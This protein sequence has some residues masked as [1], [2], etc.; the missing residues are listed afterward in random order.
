[1]GTWSHEDTGHRSQGHGDTGPWSHR[2]RG[3]GDTG[4]WGHRATGTPGTGRSP[5]VPSHPRRGAQTRPL[6]FIGSPPRPPPLPIGWLSRRQRGGPEAAVSSPLGRG[7][8]GPETVRAGRGGRDGIPPRPPPPPP[9][10]PPLTVSPLSSAFAPQRGLT[11]PPP[12]AP[13]GPSRP[14]VLLLTTPSTSGGG[15]W[16]AF[17]H[18]S[19]NSLL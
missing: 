19:L 12:S 4:P 13:G 16:R 2:S 8:A 14:P 1:M 15:R 11:P 3:H 10:N 7:R 5:R 6:S 17:P 9:L 18:P